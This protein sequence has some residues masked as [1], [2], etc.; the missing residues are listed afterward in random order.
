MSKV[1]GIGNALI[2]IMT[3]LDSDDV[4]QLFNLPKGSMQLVDGNLSDIINQGTDSFEKTIA[5]GGSAANTIHGLA[6]LGIETGFL[7]KVGKDELG[8]YF[9]KDMESSGIKPLLFESDTSSGKAIALI[10]PDSERT[11]ATFLG[12]AVE[13]GPDDLSDEIY[14]GYDYFHIEGYLVQNHHLIEQAVKLAKKNGLKICLDMASYNVVEDNLEFLQ[15]IVKEYVDI[16]FANEEEA[17]AFTGK[18]AEEALH[19]FASI[20]DIAVVKVG[21]MGS[22]IKQGNHVFRIHAI[23]AKSIDTTGAGDL[24]AAGFIYGLIKGF[25]LDIC[26]KIGSI[27]AGK[28]IEVVGPKMTP[29]KWDE[30]HQMLSTL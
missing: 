16:V 30:V 13:M 28:T 5:S 11:F 26:G 7:G 18:E 19:D 3:R 29:D 2:D 20:C 9:K 24:Y 8:L 25:S 22:L 21:K 14:K 1:L 12:A 6:R 4:L 27:L 17:K 23:T 15:R 10:S